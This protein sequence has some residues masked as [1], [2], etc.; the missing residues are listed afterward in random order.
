MVTGCNPLKYFFLNRLGWVKAGVDRHSEMTV[1]S[2]KHRAIVGGKRWK[3]DVDKRWRVGWDQARRSSCRNWAWQ[4][5]L[6]IRGPPDEN[7]A[8]AGSCCWW[9]QIAVHVCTAQ[10]S[11]GVL[12]GFYF[13]VFCWDLKCSNLPCCL[14]RFHN[15]LGVAFTCLLTSPHNFKK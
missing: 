13:L 9:R 15:C 5:G 4:V 6:I 10:N 3:W 8:R 14:L 1:T 7:H 11:Q 2:S 12:V